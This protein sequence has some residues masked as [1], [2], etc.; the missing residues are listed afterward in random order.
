MDQNAPNPI[1]EEKFIGREHEIAAYEQWLT[2]PNACRI[3]Y[4]YDAA[5]EP[6]KKGGV[7]K[8]KLLQECIKITKEKYKNIV[9]VSVDFF[10]IADRNGRRI[11]ERVYKQL[12]DTYPDW[13]A[14]SFGKALKDGKNNTNSAEIRNILSEA[15]TSDLRELDA[16]LSKMHPGRYCALVIVLDTFDVIQDN[17][18]VAV[19][20]PLQKF[21]DDYHFG[22]I[23]FLLAGRYDINWAQPNWEGR[24]QEVKG[25][26]LEPFTRK[27]TVN[28]MHSYEIP[29][30]SG[31][32]EAAI[33]WELTGGRPILLGLVK[34]LIGHNTVKLEDLLSVP[35]AEFE[36]HLVSQINN[37]DKPVNWLVLFMAHAYHRFNFP[38]LEWILGRASS[39]R[40]LVGEV[41]KR[42]LEELPSLSFVRRA[43]DKSGD[44][45]LHD[46]MRPLIM[47]HCWQS[48]DTDKSY[49]QEVSRHVIQYYEQELAN[50]HD[51]L[52]RQAY[53]VQILY[54]KAF[55][56][57]NDGMKYF[58][59]CFDEA[60]DL[61]Q[62]A[63]ARN[64]LQEIQKFSEPS[65][66]N[67]YVYLITKKLSPYQRADLVMKEARLFLKEENRE[68][69]L[70]YHQQLLDEAE[71]DWREEHQAEILYDLGECH[72]AMAKFQEASKAFNDA[73]TLE[74]KRNNQQKIADILNALGYISRRQGQFDQAVD[75]YQE[76]LRIYKGLGEQPEYLRELADILNNLSNVYRLLGKIDKAL[77]YC[78]RGLQ[79]RERLSS[80]N[81]VSEV[82][83][84]FSHATLGHIY[85]YDGDDVNA[86]KHLK[87][88]LDAFTRTNNKQGLVACHNRFGQIQMKRGKLDEALDHFKRAFEEAT[89]T[90]EGAQITSLNRQ[91]HI[92]GLRQECEEAKNDFEKA[93]ALAQNVHDSYQEVESRID[94][95]RVL[96][97]L[98]EYE[99]YLQEL[100]KAATIAGQQHYNKLLGEIEKL[101]G[102]QSY[103]QQRHQ[104]AFLHYAKLCHFMAQY[105]PI[106]YRKA[107]RFLTDKLLESLKVDDST[108]VATALEVLRSY[109]EEQQLAS[110]FPEF[111]RVCDNVDEVNS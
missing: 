84:G 88:A 100:D 76:S 41:D 102:D 11:A 103:Q 16:Y 111:L 33:L 57:I 72:L 70:A 38:L 80:N 24:E 36:A 75:Y 42:Q 93:I 81:E 104:G 74:R 28:Y 60:I 48:L 83:I 56:E 55:L 94:L 77:T 21:P 53:I 37:I 68:M 13:S 59:Q 49:R 5:S 35:P 106:E 54:H 110:T 92:H 109:W 9:I 43:T 108:E 39:L 18:S 71:K 61:W 62:N 26:A 78:Q 82:A 66:L 90:D 101:Q 69:A 3:L 63:Y 22:H 2:D 86:E 91:G 65:S 15:L 14:D 47:K 64:L 67:Q 8:T 85:L 20:S 30:E 97:N 7:G 32:P 45:T 95:A 46:E 89:R 44:F 51:D 99:L 79:I 34:D 25:I 19:F 17:P 6:D 87:T 10:S 96:A 52:M 27:E 50:E 1:T 105:N 4:V 29:L 98:E 107:L 40:T 12:K 31:S 73:L 58:T 23:R